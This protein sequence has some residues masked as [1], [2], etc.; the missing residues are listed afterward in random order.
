MPAAALNEASDFAFRT[1]LPIVADGMGQA[2]PET[3]LCRWIRV[4]ARL[5]RTGVGGEGFAMGYVTH[6]I[7]PWMRQSAIGPA[8]RGAEH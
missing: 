4:I 7:V 5:W 3:S 8:P 6:D 2:L 1:S